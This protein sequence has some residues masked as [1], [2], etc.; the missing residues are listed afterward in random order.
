M[1][2]FELVVRVYRF[3]EIHCNNN[4]LRFFPPAREL[5]SPLLTSDAESPHVL[6]G[7]AEER[8]VRTTPDQ[9]A[10]VL[11]SRREADPGGGDVA[12]VAPSLWEEEQWT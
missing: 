9:A 3:F 7:G 10:V 2:S 12:V 11:S 5:P 4:V 6:Y 8:V 1:K